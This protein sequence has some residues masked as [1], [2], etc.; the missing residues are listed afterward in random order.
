MMGG[1][2]STM[3]ARYIAV[4]AVTVIC[5]VLMAENGPMPWS[6][7]VN[8]D[9][10]VIS[11]VGRRM[12]DGEVLYVD[13]WEQK[14]PVLYGL[15][16]LFWKLGVTYRGVAA[17]EVAVSCAVLSWTM[18]VLARVLVEVGGQARFKWFL[19]SIPLLFTQF[20]FMCFFPGMHIAEVYALPF[21]AH[22]LLAIARVRKGESGGLVNWGLCGAGAAVAFFV[23]FPMALLFAALF[24]CA[25]LT[26]RHEDPASRAKLAV[27]VVTAFS[28][29]A[30][31]LAFAA[32]AMSSWR[33]FDGFLENYIGFSANGY[34]AF[35]MTALSVVSSLANMSLVSPMRLAAFAWLAYA[36]LRR[37]R[38][39]GI[40]WWPAFFGFM[41]Y[42]Q[43][44]AWPV[45]GIPL[46]VFAPFAIAAFPPVR[47]IG[48]FPPD[49]LK[50]ALAL[51][52]TLAPILTTVVNHVDIE[53]YEQE[54]DALTEVVAD[55]SEEGDSLYVTHFHL[56]Y[57][58]ECAGLESTDGIP[59]MVNA[60]DGDMMEAA[61]DEI[62]ACK[63]EV[64]AVIVSDDQEGEHGER[65][66]WEEA[67]EGAGYSVA[68]EPEPDSIDK[69]RLYVRPAGDW[70]ETLHQDRMD[71]VH[72]SY[73]GWA[74]GPGR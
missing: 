5:T 57:L 62:R 39:F 61:L 73:R 7:L 69:V 53:E 13:V 9:W 2:L 24:L 68:W 35:G 21:L 42:W 25:V 1:L 71:P 23:K 58:Y 30:A 36:S 10:D 74:F 37:R 72:G 63:W 8:G 6:Y 43:V 49:V 56:M 40:T 26:W 16:M 14:G 45:Y 34:N 66:M 20:P 65:K 60:Y 48:P 50:L 47:R 29:M 3:R 12:A 4:V 11:A 67:L 44:R 64:V 31:V 70:D 51:A 17:I 46:G 38:D 15:W 22:G 54:A 19:L 55:C 33:M 27:P 41:M 28:C 18:C 52:I 32:A 59:A